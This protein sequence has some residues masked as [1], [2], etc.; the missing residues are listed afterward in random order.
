MFFGFLWRMPRIAL[1]SDT[2]GYLSDEIIKHIMPCDEV[3]HA[4]DIG[5]PEV[6]DKLKSIKPLRAIYGNID[7]GVLRVEYKETLHFTIDGVSFLMTHIGGA[8]GRY[9]A[10]L[11][12]LLQYL[13]P[14]V[15]ICGHSHILRVVYDK[16]FNLLHLNPGAA[17]R[18][19]FHQVRT[20]LRFSIEGGKLTNMEAIELG[21]RATKRGD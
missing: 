10:K 3:W 7:G 5:T 13:K 15:F 9:P 11:K 16:P 18:H 17:G 6:T 8:P 4:G 14:N 2:H 12:Q 21:P 1:I 20:M 19:G